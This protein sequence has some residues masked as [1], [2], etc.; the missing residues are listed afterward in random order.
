M[1]RVEYIVIS[2][3]HQFLLL[4]VMDCQYIL[5][6]FIKMTKA[7][8]LWIGRIYKLRGIKCLYDYQGKQH[9]Q[10]Q[11]VQ[12][13]AKDTSLSVQSLLYVNN[14]WDHRSFMAVKRN[15]FMYIKIHKMP[16]IWNIQNTYQ[17]YRFILS[18]RWRHR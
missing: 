13:R 6:F 9:K 11:K 12:R 16:C 15:F 3:W 14:T 5:F 8:N 1:Q 10:Q 2:A 4:I 18:Q 17:K 7:K